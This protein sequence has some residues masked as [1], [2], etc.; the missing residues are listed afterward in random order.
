MKTRSP[1]TDNTENENRTRTST[2]SGFTLVELAVVIV[3]IAILA[4][5]LI[6]AIGGAIGKAKLAKIGIE[7]SNIDQALRTYKSEF[8]EF[9]PDFTTFDPS[10]NVLNPNGDIRGQQ[11]SPEVEAHLSRNFRRRDGGDLPVMLDP[12]NTGEDPNPTQEGDLV[13]V[14]GATA[15]LIENLDPAEA[16][17]FWLGGFSD[18]P[19][20]PISGNGTRQPFY[21]FDRSRLEDRDG[22]GFLE[23]YPPG[24]TAPYVYYRALQGVGTNL[25]YVRANS[26]IS[27]STR[28]HSGGPW[29]EAVTSSNN[30]N[31][32]IPYFSDRAV[33]GG[34]ADGDPPTEAAAATTYQ[35]ISASLDGNFG[36]GNRV[37]T[38]RIP[39]SD[40]NA[41]DDLTNFSEGRTLKDLVEQ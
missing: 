32:P 25:A 28:S 11:L 14:T 4:A 2:A 22:D 27:T 34:A 6:P 36:V 18:D 9:P 16:L 3:I 38:D 19:Q 15:H 8:G 23:Y 26:Y 7:I 37:I 24:S 21:E 40:R 12:V 17:P 5:M 31:Y 29:L 41:E 30:N 13:S 35:L 39:T 10:D 33:P 20:F 1:K